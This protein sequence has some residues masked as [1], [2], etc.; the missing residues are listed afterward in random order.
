MVR[1]FQKYITT[2]KT[3]NKKEKGNLYIIE[4]NS[5]FL[6]GEAER[7]FILFYV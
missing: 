6:D 2:D 7:P 4:H 5:V 1:Y 3:D